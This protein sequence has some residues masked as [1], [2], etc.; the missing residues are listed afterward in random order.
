MSRYALAPIRRGALTA[1]FWQK[2]CVVNDTMTSE[3]NIRFLLAAARLSSTFSSTLDL[4]FFRTALLSALSKDPFWSGISS[5][6]IISRAG[7]LEFGIRQLLDQC[8]IIRDLVEQ[9][10]EAGRTT[11]CPTP[12]HSHPHSATI[13]RRESW[14][15]EKGR[16]KAGDYGRGMGIAVT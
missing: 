8:D 3:P 16:S 9:S 11:T 10:A 14:I 15:L 1:D 12:W 4:S 2:A 5:R 6:A 13:R 7:Q